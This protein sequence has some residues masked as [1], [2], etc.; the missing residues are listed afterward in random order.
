MKVKG[1]KRIQDFIASDLAKK[2]NLPVRAIKTLKRLEEVELLDEVGQIFLGN[3]WVDVVIEPK[4][5]T[6]SRTFKKSV[7]ATNRKQEIN[8]KN[9]E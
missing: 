8:D 4:S 5:E 3:N 7:L 1:R 6:K 9:K 2:F